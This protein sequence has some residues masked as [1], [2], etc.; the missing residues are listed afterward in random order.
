MAIN[1][2]LYPPNWNAISRRV[3]LE[4]GNRC[5]YCGVANGWTLPSGGTVVLTVHHMGTPHEDRNQPGNPADK[6]DCRRI[7]LI[8]LCQKCHF[9]AEREIQRHPAPTY[10]ETI[11]FG[12]LYAKVCA[13]LF[14][15][16]H[17]DVNAAPIL[18][19]PSLGNAVVELDYDR[20]TKQVVIF[21]K[22]RGMPESSGAFDLQEFLDAIAVPTAHLQSIVARRDR[23]RAT[24]RA[25][26]EA[27]LPDDASA[28][29]E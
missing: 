11:F 25:S 1:R 6:L 27:Q 23:D 18:Y 3:R 19:L 8:A 13:R 20:A 7:N 24:R 4:A 21:G 29:L 5:E 14:K 26:R 28:L 17:L 22:A 12:E 2:S 9:R 16:A 10:T 15:A